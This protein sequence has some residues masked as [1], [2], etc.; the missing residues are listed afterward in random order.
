MSCTNAS[1]H[2][3]PSPPPVIA[4]HCVAFLVN[5]PFLLDTADRYHAPGST[6]LTQWLARLHLCDFIQ[7]AL[8]SC[9]PFD[10]LRLLLDLSQPYCCPIFL[11]Q[12]PQTGLT[13][14]APSYMERVTRQSIFFFFSS[15]LY[16]GPWVRLMHLVP[17]FS[18]TAEPHMYRPD[19]ARVQKCSKGFVNHHSCTL[20]LAG[21]QR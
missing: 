20:P 11:F 13:F 9:L 19:T 1:Q 16:L 8:S 15:K 7:S 18:P 2:R 12:I 14:F 5:P 10:R 21:S 17:I 3:D 6:A 4:A